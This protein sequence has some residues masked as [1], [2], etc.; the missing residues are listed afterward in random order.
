MQSRHYSVNFTRIKWEDKPSYL[1]VLKD[2]SSISNIENQK[3]EQK[4]KNLMLSSL[5]HSIRTP[6][7]SIMAANQI[8]RLPN[9]SPEKRNELLEVSCCSCKILDSLISNAVDYTDF[10]TDSFVPQIQDFELVPAL[11]EI[12]EVS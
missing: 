5:S 11:T 7:N 12:Q 6:L 1:F 2:I 4:Y 8:I 9:T 3:A 10:E